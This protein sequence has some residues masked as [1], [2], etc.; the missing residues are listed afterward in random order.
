MEREESKNKDK[1]RCEI[2]VKSEKLYFKSKKITAVDIDDI[3]ESIRR[4]IWEE[5]RT[6]GIN[7]DSRMV[8]S[9]QKG[10]EEINNRVS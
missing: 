2:I 10:E 1:R 5:D 3:Q 9:N 4:K 7:S 8:T 6:K